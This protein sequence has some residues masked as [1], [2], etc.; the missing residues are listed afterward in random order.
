MKTLEYSVRVDT[1]CLTLR[2]KTVRVYRLR[3]TH[4]SCLPIKLAAPYFT[5]AATRTTSPLNMATLA[6]AWARAIVAALDEKPCG[7]CG[8]KK[9]S[10]KQCPVD[11]PKSLGRVWDNFPKNQRQ[12][13]SAHLRTLP[14][15]S[16]VAIDPPAPE[17][18]SATTPT[19]TN[20]GVPLAASDRNNSMVESRPRPSQAP[21]TPTVRSSNAPF[22]PR[23]TPSEP[24]PTPS[25][26]G[27]SHKQPREA[28]ISIR[29][30]EAPMQIALPA[31]VLLDS[32]ALFAGKQTHFAKLKA[33]SQDIPSE[34][35]EIR[36]GFANTAS[37]PPLSVLANY[38]K[39]ELPN[40][41]LHKY[42]VSV[43]VSDD[44]VT[45]GED[46]PRGK[47]EERM[48]WFVEN[49]KYLRNA[50]EHFAT[51]GLSIIIAWEEV[52]KLGRGTA[53]HDL[54]VLDYQTRVV[55][56]A[57]T[58]SSGTKL[59]EFAERYTLTYHGKVAVEDLVKASQGDIST[60][61]L[62]ANIGLARQ[63]LN[64]VLSKATLSSTQHPFQIGSNKYFTETSSK[65][66]EN[67]ILGCKGFYSS[68][69]TGMGSPLLNVSTATTA[70][71]EPMSVAKFLK[72]FRPVAKLECSRAAKAALIGVKVRIKN[73]GDKIKAIKEFG[74]IPSEQTFWRAEND[75][76]TVLEHIQENKRLTPTV[77]WSVQASEFP[78]AN[79]GTFQKKEWFPV[80]ILDIVEH[81]PFKGLLSGKA[82][83]NMINFAR[84]VPGV[85]R[86]AIV[87]RGR[88]LLGITAQNDADSALSKAKIHIDESLLEL[89]ARREVPRAVSYSNR[90]ALPNKINGSWD[91]KANKFL[92]TTT[93]LGGRIMFLLPF[94]ETETVPENDKTEM[95]KGLVAQLKKMGIQLPGLGG[96]AID[97]ATDFD[98]VNVLEVVTNQRT[99]RKIWNDLQVEFQRQFDYAKANDYKLVVYFNEDSTSKHAT[100][101]SVLKRISEQRMGIHS[102]CLDKSKAHKMY[103][104]GGGF[105][106]YMANAAMKV[107][108]KLGN[109]NHTVR[110]DD[111]VTSRYVNKFDS[112][113]RTSKLDLL[114]LGADV[115]HTQKE[116]AVDMPSLAAV[117]GSVDGTFGKFLGSM[118]P[119]GRDTEVSQAFTT[120]Q[121]TH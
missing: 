101:F 62:P 89:P 65:L 86:D 14:A 4:S 70:F 10:L 100:A 107:N 16:P 6:A 55:R 27:G 25:G 1:N 119:Q 82:A 34:I 94:P 74:R 90:N 92:S 96:Y 19:L 9:H 76:P 88:K 33:E 28:V 20:S 48:S 45:D 61:P 102:L 117:V 95:C 63:A 11:D 51:D 83:S 60:L 104:N 114:I 108:L 38:F 118:R 13:A 109:T 80:E 97:M 21:R 105:L 99:T 56:E 22:I 23:G 36:P 77:Y 50:E 44:D 81:Q 5:L 98:T 58:L 120:L 7:R 40:A 12:L 15:Y 24:R 121:A 111:N 35:H 3:N 71:Y 39:V 73:Q 68:F 66:L 46:A 110:M 103:K 32:R 42:V 93:P 78:C 41:L 43:K 79:L 59:D 18:T 84:Q 112:N 69:K 30:E 49:S 8:D 29:A 72:T 75:E 54:E 91:L 116:S 64:I 113:T 52:G 106:Q 47:R 87:D 2:D 53:S 26:Y 57:K 85:N 67:C 37:P 31:S 17:V 115:T